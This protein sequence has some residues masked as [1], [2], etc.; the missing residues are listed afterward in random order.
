MGRIGSTGSGW[1]F[2]EA[3]VA[4]FQLLENVETIIR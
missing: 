1:R 3:L 4:W 2:E